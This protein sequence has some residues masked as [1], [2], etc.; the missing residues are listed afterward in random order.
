MRWRG[1][2]SET[3]SLSVFS[4]NMN[5]RVYA[6]LLEKLQFKILYLPLLNNIRG[7]SAFRWSWTKGAYCPFAMDRRKPTRVFS[8]S[9]FTTPQNRR[10]YT[11]TPLSQEIKSTGDKNSSNKMV[12]ISS[13]PRKG[14][15]IPTAG[16]HGKHCCASKSMAATLRDPNSVA[17]IQD[18]Q[19]KHIHLDW[20]VDFE[21]SKI[22]GSATLDLIKMEGGQEC[23]KLD[24][25]HLVIHRVTLFGKEQSQVNLVFKIDTKA[26]KFGGLL[27]IDLPTDV[28][29]TFKVKYSP[30]HCC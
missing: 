8:S 5:M 27:L 30:S 4:W 25:S 15:S 22:V 24:C 3:I 2:A 16:M 19:T 21:N 28:Q 26:N 1:N 20:K 13:S 12:S 29:P 6:R 17:N 10:N 9:A 23:L 14:Y 7:I 18:F 11:S